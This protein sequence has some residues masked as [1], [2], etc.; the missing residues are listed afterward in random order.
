MKAYQYGGKTPKG[1][2][3]NKLEPKKITSTPMLGG[4]YS[5]PSKP[6]PLKPGK[7]EKAS[8]LDILIGNDKMQKLLRGGSKGMC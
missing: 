5:A 3:G 6:Q 8:R 2:S 4:K 7:S 1:K